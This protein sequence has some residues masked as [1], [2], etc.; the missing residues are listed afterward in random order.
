MITPARI[1]KIDPSLADLSDEELKEVV[2][3]LYELGQLVF[4][5]WLTDGFGSKRPLGLLASE[6]EKPRI[7]P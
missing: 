7:K 1:R 5:Q 3:K 4:E 6:Q 2:Q